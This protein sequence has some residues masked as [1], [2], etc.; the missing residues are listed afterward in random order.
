MLRVPFKEMY[1]AYGLGDAPVLK[2][3]KNPNTHVAVLSDRGH[4]S[5]RFLAGWRVVFFDAGKNRR[6]VNN[7]KRQ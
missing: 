2:K 3:Q 1:G 4:K 6:G 7:K 5:T